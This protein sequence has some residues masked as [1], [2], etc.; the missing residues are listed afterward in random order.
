MRRRAAHAAAVALAGL[1]IA[2][3]GGSPCRL[4][5]TAEFV[6]LGKNPFAAVQPTPTGRRL[7]TLQAWRNEIYMGYGD[8]DENTGPIEVS[9]YNPRRH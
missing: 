9:A 2:G 5:A 6:S 8:Y 1:L 3:C 7:H 4:G